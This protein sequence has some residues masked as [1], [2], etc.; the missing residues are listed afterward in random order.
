MDRYWP[1]LTHSNVIQGLDSF[2]GEHVLVDMFELVG[3]SSL[4]VAMVLACFYGVDEGVDLWFG[5]SDP[6]LSP[7]LRLRLDVGDLDRDA[8]FVCYDDVVRK[9][10]PKVCNLLLDMGV[11][12]SAYHVELDDLYGDPMVFKVQRILPLSASPCQSFEVLDVFQH[13]SLL[14]IFL[15]SY[16]SHRASNSPEVD[17]DSADD[18]ALD[19]LSDGSALVVGPGDVIELGDNCLGSK[20][21]RPRTT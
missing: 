8:S 6:L 15:R 5:G 16:C 19:S 4:D 12:V 9:I 21:K 11:G 2:L 20:S 1:T 17:V 7:R 10:A 14:D 3:N 13:S 18:I